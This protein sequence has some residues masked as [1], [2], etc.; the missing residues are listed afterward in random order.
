MQNLFPF[1]VAWFHV[2]LDSLRVQ[3]L[4]KNQTPERNSAETTTFCIVS[5]KTHTL[6]Q[7]HSVFGLDTPKVAEVL[8]KCSVKLD[9]LDFHISWCTAFRLECSH[10][11]LLLLFRISN[12]LWGHRVL[13]WPVKLLKLAW[14]ISLKCLFLSCLVFYKYNK[15]KNTPCHRYAIFFPLFLTWGNVLKVLIALTVV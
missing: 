2:L 15:Q 14:N 3:A 4:N 7:V 8:L 12:D 10:K 9:S 1:H 5:T 6:T 11:I 13:L